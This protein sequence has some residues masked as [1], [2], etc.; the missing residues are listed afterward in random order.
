MSGVLQTSRVPISLVPERL[1]ADAVHEQGTDL[2]ELRPSRDQNDVVLGNAELAGRVLE[3]AVARWRPLIPA[4]VRLDFSMQPQEQTQWCWAAVS[5]SVALYYQPG[6][7]WTQCQ[8]V[9][10]EKGQTTCCQNG[11][12]PQCN[13]PHVLDEP[14]ARAGVLDHMEFGTVD[15][16]V[17]ST[18]IEEHRPVAWRIGWSGGGGHFAVIE[19]YQRHGGEWVA[20]DDP[21]FGQSDLAVST[22]T[23][24][25][26]QGSGTW[27]HTYLT[28]RPPF[29]FVHPVKE[30]RLPWELWERIGQQPV[31]IG[32]GDT[33]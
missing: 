4:W 15:Y 31:P 32:G 8:M 3:Q 13:Q 24:G 33:S 23:G 11:S 16:D 5:V 27:T 7:G 2:E 14:L 22:L 28:R 29:P 9:N 30:I 12:T 20:V 25:M 19:G 10:L 1:I 18:H 21:W 17:I 26:Y 6:S